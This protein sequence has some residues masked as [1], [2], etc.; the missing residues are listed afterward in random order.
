VDANIPCVCKGFATLPALR[1][2][3]A[4][5][6]AQSWPAEYCCPVSDGREFGRVVLGIHFQR[7]AHAVEFDVGSDDFGFL[8]GPRESGQ[9]QGSEDA[10]DGNDNQK[11]DEG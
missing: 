4:A 1:A 3:T 2:P 7:Q 9:E 8:F 6:V 5:F 11:L 10:N